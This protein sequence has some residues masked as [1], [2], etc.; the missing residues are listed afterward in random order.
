[1]KVPEPYPSARA[2]GSAMKGAAQRAS[3]ID[4]SVSVAERIRQEQ[5]RRFL[6]RIFSEEEGTFLLKGGTGILARVPNA[7]A[8]VDIDLFRTGYTLEESV[9]ELRR[10]ASINIGDHFRFEYRS[11]RPILVGGEQGYAEGLE[12]RFDVFLG[13]KPMGG[14]K[15]DLARGAGVTAEIELQHPTAALTLPKLPS[16]PY[17]LYPVVDQIADKVCATIMKYAGRDSTREK[18][19]VDLVVFASI[20]GI[21]SEPLRLALTAEC[22]RRSLPQVDKYIVPS[23]W[24]HSY[25]RMARDVPACNGYSTIQAAMQLMESFLDPILSGEV[26][27]A[28]WDPSLRSWQ[29]RTSEERGPWFE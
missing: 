2:V 4:P 14:L 16:N 17:R 19:L 28:I 12:V 1:M 21:L 6:S 9:A 29:A 24:G 26:S 8:T 15:V 20:Q 3:K 25:S 11:T 23:A 13:V 7:R 10:L 27:E 22:R 5:F 18:D